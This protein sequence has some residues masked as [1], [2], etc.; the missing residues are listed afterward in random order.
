MTGAQAPL[1]R[2]LLFVPGDRAERFGKAEASGAH[3]VLLDLEDAV[4]PDAK[5][6]ARLSVASWLI[7]RPD[8]RVHAIVRI[9]SMGSIW[10]EDD[11]CWVADL[12]PSVG[13]MLPK[14]E[15]HSLP[16]VA[17]RLDGI[18]PLY[19]LVE[20][21]SGVLGLR[22]MAQVQGLTRLAFGNLDFGMD[23]GINPGDDEIEFASVR[24]AFVL[25]SRLA[26]LPAPVDG[27]S[28]ET[29]DA[30][31]IAKHAARSR[32]FGFGGKLCIHPRQVAP[33]NT[34]FLPTEADVVWAQNVIAAFDASGGGVVALD[35][36]MVDR[37]VAERARQILENAGA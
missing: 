12:P 17:A 22:A 3:G 16:T 36:E 26:G 29:S 31:V 27:V 23:A 5:P 33:I 20:T 14:S 37:P 7:E 34:A 32:R 1:L 13:V 4:A 30:E 10:F 8:V 28:L 35:G 25:E 11:L 6:G 15:P 24:S 9:N 21:V 19:A 18:R 2:S